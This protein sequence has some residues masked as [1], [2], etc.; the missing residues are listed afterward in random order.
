M[1]WWML[2]SF[3]S[4]RVWNRL[5][6]WIWIWLTVA[7]VIPFG[8]EPALVSSS[9]ATS[10]HIGQGWSGDALFRQVEVVNLCVSFTVVSGLLL[11]RVAVAAPGALRRL[12]PL[13]V[14]VLLL[15]QW[16]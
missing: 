5:L 4:G 1:Y 7:L 2:F 11:A 12:V 16:I 10:L 9:P 8:L 6:L 3:P 15:S 14:S 13:F